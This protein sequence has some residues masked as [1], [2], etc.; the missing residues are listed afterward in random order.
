M[1]ATWQRMRSGDWKLVVPG[2]QWAV[3]FVWKTFDGH[4]YYVP[5]ELIHPMAPGSLD[6]GQARALAEHLYETVERKRAQ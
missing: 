2:R 6:F 1:S 3:G 4:D 5:G